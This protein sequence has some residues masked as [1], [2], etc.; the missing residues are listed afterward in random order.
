MREHDQ[1]ADT[2][3]RQYDSA[4]ETQH[5]RNSARQQ[6]WEQQISNCRQSGSRLTPP[7]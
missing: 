3:T 6:A 1:R 5:G 2:L 7:A 4:E